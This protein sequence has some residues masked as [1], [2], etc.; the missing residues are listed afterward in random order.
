MP[1]PSR[2]PAAVA[3]VAL[4][5]AAAL[6]AAVPG[7]AATPVLEATLDLSLLPSLAQLQA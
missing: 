7:G 2:R 1:L 4:L 5:V 3:T 6:L